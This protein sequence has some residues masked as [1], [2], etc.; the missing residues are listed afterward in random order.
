MTALSISIFDL[1]M[2]HFLYVAISLIVGAAAALEANEDGKPAFIVVV[3]FLV[4]GMFWLPLLI[5]KTVARQ[6]L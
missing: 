3:A 5:G 1:L 4:Y 6:L 2:L